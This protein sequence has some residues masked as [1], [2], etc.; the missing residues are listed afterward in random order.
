M[1][2]KRVI[3]IDT[4]AAGKSIKDL[5]AQIAALRKQL[6]DYAVGSEEATQT[7]QKLQQAQIDLTA[8]QKGAVDSTGKLTTT[9]NGLVAQMAKLKAEQKNVDISTEEGRAT[10]AKYAEE[11]NGIND[12]LKGLDASNGVFSRNVGN[13]AQ[14][15]Q[16]AFT[17]MG[18]SCATLQ[19]GL[20]KVR[21]GMNLLLKHPLMLALAG[22]VLIVTKIA[23]AIKG[24]EEN[25]NKV[26]L[27]FAPLRAAGTAISNIF[28]KLG[29]LV[30]DVIAKFGSVS[31]W[32]E[33]VAK[34][35]AEFARSLGLDDFANSIENAFSKAKATVAVEK[36]LTKAEQD[37]AKR[38]REI[39]VE[40]KK[41]ELEGSEARAKIAE[42]DKYTAQQR[43]AFLNTYT[44]N[45]KKQLENNLEI[46]KEELRIAEGRAAQSAND[47]AANDALAQAQAKVYEQQIAYNNGLRE[48]NAQRAEI[49]ASM[50]S[51][52]KEI[53]EVTVET[54]KEVEEAVDP[55][56][57]LKQKIL[58]LKA[59]QS[60]KEAIIQEG[61]DKQKL[62]LMK[63]YEED[64]LSLSE[65]Y[66][67]IRQIEANANVD[68][69]NAANEFY[70]KLQGL[71]D[72]Q[73]LNSQE[74]ADM[75][76]ETLGTIVDTTTEKLLENQQKVDSYIAATIDSLAI[77]QQ[78]ASELASIG[79][80]ISSEWANTLGSVSALM[81]TIGNQLKEGGK[82]WQ[83]YA[84]IA[85]ASLGVVSN[86]L[87][88]VADEQDTTTREGFEQQ[89]RLQIG[90][91]TMTML[92]GIM[93]AW[94]SSMALPAPASFILGAIQTAATAALGAVQI[95]KIKQQTF[96]GSGSKSGSS[97]SAS[98]S[99]IASL[100]A[101][102]QY[103]QDV[104]GASIENAISNTKVYVTESDIKDT[105]SK[106]EVAENESKF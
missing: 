76:A 55:K 78:T 17:A 33:K 36:E 19:S 20:G 8:A 87:G 16:E 53:E 99:A 38:K 106:V 100:N 74:Y 15:F 13:Y 68:R 12:E 58:Q 103:T 23:Q 62:L 63:Q 5:K 61:I 51:Q 9:Y 54:P 79:N 75:L 82:G 11:I 35:F 45:Y 27:A 43:L 34:K 10:F 105:S 86:I 22:I 48:V 104:Q 71:E 39:L 70:T 97:A 49:I 37:L 77:A 52:K 3:T 90:Q 93:G 64:Q 101:P 41:L 31:I 91:A 72:E 94:T 67:K 88:A 46:A 89:K 47:A 32:I 4:E 6:D 2:K 95:A 73:I 98:T 56:E 26:T 85:A 29:T 69:L 84:N 60:A 96:E 21:Q 50:K 40:N 30:A 14:S 102:V 59:E 25:L 80:G 92:A 57:E 1:D 28:D 65:Y 83:G 24:N 81:A 18:G 7:A 66:S 42:K 44:A